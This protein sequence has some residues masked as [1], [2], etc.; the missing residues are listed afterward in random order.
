MLRASCI[1]TKKYETARPAE[2]GPP[3]SCPTGRESLVAA[4]RLADPPR[5][6]SIL[7]YLGHR[8][9]PAGHVILQH[10]FL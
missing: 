3:D 6:H 1:G 8:Y 7:L 9:M 2:A 4:L 10:L 5:H